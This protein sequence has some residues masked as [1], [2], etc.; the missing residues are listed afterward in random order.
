MHEQS[1]S[2][3]CRYRSCEFP[4]SCSSVCF[5]P[6]SPAH[7]HK[8]PFFFEFIKAACIIQV[9]THEKHAEWN[10]NRILFPRRRYRGSGN[11]SLRFTGRFSEPLSV[12]QDITRMLE[13]SV[14]TQEAIG[15]RV[16]QSLQPM[17]L[18]SSRC[19]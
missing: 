4:P 10:K 3:C 17:W 6:N 11:V 1:V 12:S 19:G 2:Y 8:P 13:R 15:Q 18:I 9:R 16:S 5:R 7:F 14:Q